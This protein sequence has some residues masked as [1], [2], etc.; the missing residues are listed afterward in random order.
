MPAS[1]T[2][3]LLCL[4][5][6]V[7]SYIPALRAQMNTTEE[8]LSVERYQEQLEEIKVE[9]RAAIE[10]EFA[11]EKRDLDLLAQPYQLNSRVTILSLRGPNRYVEVKGNFREL[12]IASMPAY[13]RIGDQKVPWNDIH[14][15]DR[16]RLKWG[17][18]QDQ[19]PLK[20]LIAKR[21]H[22]LREMQERMA[23]VKLNGELQ[24]LGYTSEW[25]E[26]MIAV[27]GYFWE[28]PELG[29]MRVE[30]EVL[31]SELNPLI[32]IKIINR[33]EQ[34]FIATAYL[35][36]KPLWTNLPRDFGTIIPAPLWNEDVFWVFKDDLGGADYATTLN[37][38]LT[39]SILKKDV[40]QWMLRPDAESGRGPRASTSQ[41]SIC[42]ECFGSGKVHPGLESAAAAAAA[43]AG[44][45]SPAEGE[46]APAG[47]GEGAAAEG[48]TA[49]VDEAALPTAGEVMPGRAL[50]GSTLPCPRCE[51]EGT[52]ASDPHRVSNFSVTLALVSGEN[53]IFDYTRDI[54][55]TYVRSAANAYEYQKKVAE[56][57]NKIRIDARVN[58]EANEAANEAREAERRA[59]E[60]RIAQ[61]QQ[62][63]QRIDENYVWMTPMQARQN[64]SRDTIRNPSTEYMYDDVSFPSTITTDKD[65]QIKVE[66]LTEWQRSISD[67]NI[68]RDEREY[69]IFQLNYRIIKG[70]LPSKEP[71]YLFQYMLRGEHSSGIDPLRLEATVTL[72]EKQTDRQVPDTNTYILDATWFGELI[73]VIPV[74]AEM[75]IN[76]IADIKVETKP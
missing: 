11:Q 51:G 60:E 48:G 53:R 12:N 40:G 3:L 14:P 29:H 41:R 18:R 33:T 46:T 66:K 72:V 2:R 24:R 4:L 37:E 65:Q 8:R 7:L 32:Q 21:R 22:Q 39:L 71:I 61:L 45:G 76:G 26:R 17:A 64:S 44:T 58:R 70:F 47:E 59:E 74:D 49:P 20:D 25:R 38:S 73:G 67:V 36:N 10:A 43:A 13:A 15:L 28:K 57:V 6:L 1:T 5:A 50:P 34:G 31:M 16:E 69:H 35:K 75:L 27:N 30:L 9:V 56:H 68:R 19:T 55:D 23:N 63:L 54:A 62:R 42:P 52:L